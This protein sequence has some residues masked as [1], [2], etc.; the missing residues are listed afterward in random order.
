[1]RLSNF[2]FILSSSY[3]YIFVYLLK[4]RQ[5]AA[6]KKEEYANNQFHNRTK[7]VMYCI[8]ILHKNV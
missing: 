1:M 8:L 2:L 4:L 5:M 6:F 3:V 7:C